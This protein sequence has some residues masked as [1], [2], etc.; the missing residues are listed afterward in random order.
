METI[1]GST[2]GKIATDAVEVCTLPDFSVF[3][4]R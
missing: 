4:M 2:T 3:G 1:L